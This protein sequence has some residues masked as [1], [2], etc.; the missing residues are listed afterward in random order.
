VG[1]ETHPGLA[2]AAQRFRYCWRA[3]ADVLAPLSILAMTL[4]NNDRASRSTLARPMTL[5]GQKVFNAGN[6]WGGGHEMARINGASHALRQ[7]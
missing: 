4:V 3:M 7:A 2:V 5:D 6:S 1:I